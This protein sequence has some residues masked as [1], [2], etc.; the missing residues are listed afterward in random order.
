MDNRTIRFP[1]SFSIGDVSIRLAGSPGDWSPFV[2][3][4]GDV[5]IPPDNEVRLDVS[6]A[7][8]FEPNVFLTLEP[9][10]LA[11]LSW[12]STRRV[13][14]GAIAYLQHLTGL[15]GLELWETNIGDEALQY[16]RQL[17]NL[18]WLDLGDTKITDDGLPHLSGLYLLK[19]LALLNDR[20][21]DKGLPHL[22]VLA[23]LERLDLMKTPLTDE[24]VETLCRMNQLKSLRIFNTCITEK[25]YKKLRSTLPDCRVKYYHPHHA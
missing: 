24:G 18:R 23:S 17:S 5:M 7:V 15:R 6:A 11:A 21:T 10:A 22:V 25:G 14:N 3:A 13:T 1:S 9:N 4:I 2:Q 12:V 8:V 16:L 19:E 20:I